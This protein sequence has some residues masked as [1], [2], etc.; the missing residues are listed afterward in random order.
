ME[1]RSPAGGRL[2]CFQGR[3]RWSAE[4]LPLPFSS[5]A[6]ESPVTSRWYFKAFPG[7]RSRPVHEK[8]IGMMYPDDHAQEED[9]QRDPPDT[10]GKACQQA[11]RSEGFDEDDQQGGDPGQVYGT[12][13]VFHL[14]GKAR[15]A[16]PA[17]GLLGSMRE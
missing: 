11:E 16:K 15:P 9:D 7:L 12:R 1:S 14:A 10:P 2:S 8:A 4:N 5:R 6:R 3:M 17:Q 13:E